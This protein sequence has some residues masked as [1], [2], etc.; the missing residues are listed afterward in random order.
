MAK[1]KSKRRRYFIF[2]DWD[3]SDERIAYWEK[4]CEDLDLFY[5]MATKEFGKEGKAHLQGFVEFNHT[6]TLSAA[7]KCIKLKSGWLKIPRGSRYECVKYCY[8]EEGHIKLFEHNPDNG[9]KESDK[10]AVQENQWD[11]ITEMIKDGAGEYEIMVEFPGTYARCS[12]GIQKMLFNYHARTINQYREI[13][14]T[15]L[16]GPSG[17][18][19][20][21]SI[22]EGNEST[23]YRVTDYK[24][25]FD[26]YRGEKTLIFE[27][28][29]SQICIDDM[30]NYLDCYIHQLPCRY[31]N[32]VSQWNKIYLI[33][34]IPLDE[35]YIHADEE[36]LAA[37][38][39]R[40]HNNV[41]MDL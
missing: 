8:E 34:N 19:K 16:W 25:P 17:S 36:T 26:N 1:S 32:K 38:Y 5:C 37:L 41:Y 28:F 11:L 9:P 24:N 18:G 27:E 7:K 39:R 35:Q 4:L 40:I 30:L 22:L 15:Y 12:T 20:T 6:K 21:R 13:E 3:A 29:R 31:A 33:T 2:T 23:V 10:R 14:V